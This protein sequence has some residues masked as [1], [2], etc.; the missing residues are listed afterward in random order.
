[1]WRILAAAVDGGFIYSDVCEFF[2]V[3]HLTDWCPSSRH[4]NHRSGAHVAAGLLVRDG[5]SLEFSPGD[6]DPV[7]PVSTLQFELLIR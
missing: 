1:M 5:R 4:D 7:S 3:L 2:R 6:V